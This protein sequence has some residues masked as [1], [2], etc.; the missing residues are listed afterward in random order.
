[1]KALAKGRT[2]VSAAFAL[3]L[4]AACDAPYSAF[5][6]A[7]PVAADPNA[8]PVDVFIGVD[9]LSRAAFD[10]ARG[11]GAF[12]SFADGDLVTPFPGTSDYAWTRILRTGALPGYEI[13]YFDPPR[14]ELVGEG[15]PGVLEH[16]VREGILSYACY[17]RF[18]FL[19]DGYFWMK[20]GYEDP[21]AALAPTLDELFWVLARRART[22]P[23]FLAYLLNIDVL[24]HKGGPQRAA[25][26]LVEL[27]RRI[28][29]FKARHPG[30]FRFTLFGD[31]GNAH[32]K[33]R[34]IDPRDVL[35]AV[36]VEPVERLGSGE[37]LEAVPIVHVR[38]TY[39]ALH[40]RP[41][42][43]GAVAERASTHTD[44]ELA[45]ARAGV[46]AIAGISGD[47]FGI[48]QGGV[49]HFFVRDRRG[50]IALENP[51]QWRESFALDFAR[52][53]VAAAPAADSL[54]LDDA[55]AFALFRPGRYPDLVAR[56][57][58][59]F[60][61]PAASIPADVLLSLPDDVASYGFHIPG[62]GDGV[63]I[64]GFHGGLGRGGSLSVLASEAIA[65]AP[66]TRADDL[67]DLFPALQPAKP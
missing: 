6:E 28:E 11:A 23:A 59:A 55:A 57:A 1:M 22:Q 63:A 4:A 34:L 15:L 3:V 41:G 24:G 35:R 65:P 32:V 42:E 33:A 60:T 25:A 47:R 14:N 54:V 20:R 49:G 31:H 16:P 21:E 51:E 39:V 64:D 43:A 67:A 38:V 48:W 46:G 19:G 29:A 56:V 53:G 10:E 18:D 26:A 27:S 62:S 45:V 12:A 40:T 61:H 58:T 66:M 36:G 44:V 17:R 2:A 7:I 5:L 52:V 50:R 37:R 8:P 13:Q 30:R 9:G